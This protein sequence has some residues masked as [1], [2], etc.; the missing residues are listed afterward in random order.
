MQIVNPLMGPWILL[1][2]WYVHD[3]IASLKPCHRE[4]KLEAFLKNPCYW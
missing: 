3:Y 2:L 1:Q 4:T